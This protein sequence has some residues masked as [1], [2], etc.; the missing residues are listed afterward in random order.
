MMI[1]TTIVAGVFVFVLGQII[2][3]L[4]VEPWQMQRECI[5]KI[6]SNL[7]IYA[8]VY[9][10]PGDFPDDESKFVSK[11]FRLLA[12][13]LL[14]SCNRIPFYSSVTKSTIFPSVEIV[15]KVQRNLIGLSNSLNKRGEYRHN[16]DM[17][18]DIKNLLKIKLD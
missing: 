9:S 8:N 7:L 5:A 14:A 3:K 12:A 10:H 6:S 1:F 11:E 2:L 4:F 17:V 13:E 15:N 18:D 16:R